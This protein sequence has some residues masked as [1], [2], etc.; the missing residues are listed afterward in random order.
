MITKTEAKHLFVMLSS[1]QSDIQA[2]LNYDPRKI[3]C[4]SRPIMPLSLATHYQHLL[5]ENK[6]L[7]LRLKFE[8]E[9]PDITDELLGYTEDFDD[10]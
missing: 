10:E 6:I 3:N 7:L 2:S 5:N 4:T 9:K 8:A 1:I